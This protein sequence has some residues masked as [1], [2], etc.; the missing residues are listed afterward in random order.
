[1]V[2]GW[3]RS[4]GGP[5][6]AATVRAVPALPLQTGQR[7]LVQV[8]GTPGGGHGQAGLGVIVRDEQ[9]RV[10][11]WRCSQAAAM[12][13]NEAEYQ[14]LLLGL[15]LVAATY[16]GLPVR[17]LTDSRLV[18][19]QMTRRRAGRSEPLRALH[20]E[21]VAVCE[22]MGAVEFVHV[23]RTV[24]RLADALAWEALAGTGLLLRKGLR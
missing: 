22:G 6:A 2:F 3:L 1:M 11:V 23:P 17:V 10:L 8:D 21:A 12:T 18:A 4:R 9:G 5:G 16:P 14:A 15:R 13:C 24:N 20:A 19:E 7:V